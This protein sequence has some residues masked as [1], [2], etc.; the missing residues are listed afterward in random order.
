MT[1]TTHRVALPFAL[2]AFAGSTAALA[3][4]PDAMDMTAGD[5][6]TPAAMARAFALPAG[7]LARPHAGNALDLSGAFGAVT[8]GGAG[9]D[10]AASTMNTG[11]ESLL[12]IPA[13]LVGQQDTVTWGGGAASVTGRNV[14]GAITPGVESTQ[15]GAVSDPIAGNGTQKLRGIANPAFG[16]NQFFGRWCRYDFVKTNS[17][18]GG[19]GT[20]FIFQPG[21]SQD[22]RVMHDTFVTS[23]DSLWA[24]EPTGA[25]FG[26]VVTRVLWGGQNATPD[27]GLPIGP[28][29]HFYTIGPPCGFKGCIFQA[30]LTPAFYRSGAPFPG[31]AGQNVPVPVGA[32]FTMIHE[33]TAS[34]RL[35]TVLDFHDGAGEFVVYDD[36]QPNPGGGRVDRIAF[37]GAFETAGDACYIDNLRVQGVQY[38]TCLRPQGDINFDGA[39]DF[40]DLNAVLSNFGATGTPGALPGDVN[41]DGV[42]N[43]ADL[44]LVLANFGAT[45][46]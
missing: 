36:L 40:A 7:A 19:I 21:V 25:T 1:R 8:R 38:L 46:S 22:L 17:A 42:V 28:I 43:F 14:I 24:S 32:W 2:V 26:A 16:A 23:I 29:H 39:I 33:T 6:H 3:V 41:N 15:Y 37:S 34:G 30:C 45:C 27:I 12:P 35:R 11:F 4:H 18:T 13:N 9:A 31:G 20:R 5:D 44:N 10:V